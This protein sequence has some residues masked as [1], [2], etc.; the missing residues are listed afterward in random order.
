MM[1]S[2]LPLLPFADRESSLQRKFAFPTLQTIRPEVY[3]EGRDILR[4]TLPELERYWLQGGQ[5]R[6]MTSNE[7]RGVT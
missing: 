1:P 4:T 2:P 6:F 7:V 3:Q 5:R